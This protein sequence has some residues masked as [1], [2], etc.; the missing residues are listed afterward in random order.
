MLITSSFIQSQSSDNP[1]SDKTGPTS[2]AFENTNDKYKK[3]LP[4]GLIHLTR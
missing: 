2:I 4:M 3:V 1:I